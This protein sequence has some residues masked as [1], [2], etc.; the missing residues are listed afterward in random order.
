MPV[1]SLT[2][3]VMRWPAQERVEAAVRSWASTEGP[4]HPD[5]LALGMFGSYARGDSGVGSDLDL[6]AVV[7]RSAEPF[8]RRALSWDLSPLPVPAEL[9][10]Y[11]AEEWRALHATGSRFAR[12]LSRE[13]V[14]LLGGLPPGP[15]TAP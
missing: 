1:R 11:T 12:T 14:W 4:R 7:A 8:E 3:P 9:L 6:L 5:L 15:A 10:V 2:S 13:G